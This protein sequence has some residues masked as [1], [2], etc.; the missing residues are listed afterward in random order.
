MRRPSISIASLSGIVAVI[1]IGIGSLVN[2]TVLWEGLA[3]L[4]T[5]IV[6]LLSLILLIYRKAGARAFW[7]GFVIFGWG[8]FVMS[9]LSGHLF[10]TFQANE[11]P[12]VFS[13]P[14]WFHTLLSGT[15]SDSLLKPFAVGDKIR[16]TSR[17]T[18]RTVTVKSIDARSYLVEARGEKGESELTYESVASINYIKHEYY[19]SF[20]RI[21]FSISILLFGLLGGV[22]ASFVYAT[23][24][25]RQRSPASG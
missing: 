17:G 13:P 16:L 24:D 5:L 10:F 4:T 19:E 1:A 22:L 20:C 18:T 12:V 11:R 21:A 14:Y 2:A 15:V 25:N 7:L 9:A 8:I 23:K 6:L 3:F